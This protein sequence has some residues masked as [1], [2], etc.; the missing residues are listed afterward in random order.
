MDPTGWITSLKG[1]MLET[2]VVAFALALIYM[3]RENKQLREAYIHAI[4][5]FAKEAREAQV[6]GV[7]EIALTREVITPLVELTKNSVRALEQNTE[8]VKRLEDRVWRSDR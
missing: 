8:V 7:A 3:Y 2:M 6:E 5:Q 4:A 1:S